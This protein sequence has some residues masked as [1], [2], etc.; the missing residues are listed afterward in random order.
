MAWCSSG[1]APSARDSGPGPI[2][3]PP[4]SQLYNT[5]AKLAALLAATTPTALVEVE[6]LEPR[7]PQSWSSRSHS[8]R[9]PGTFVPAPRQMRTTCGTT[10][11]AAGTLSAAPARSLAS[12]MTKTARAIKSATW[13]GAFVSSLVRRGRRFP[14]Q[15]LWV[16]TGGCEH[17][18]DQDDRLRA[19]RRR[20]RVALRRSR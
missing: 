11:T 4:A 8:S 16:A 15:L 19:V 9:L 20:L 13:T 6:R 2:K 18:E 5:R 14:S 10:P 7:R 12:G 17:R 3:R 1:C